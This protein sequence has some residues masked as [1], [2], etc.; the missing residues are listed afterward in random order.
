MYYE[1]HGKGTPLL[2]LHGFTGTSWGL[3]SIFQAFLQDYQLIIPDLRGHGRTTNPKKTYT[4][5]QVAEDLLSLLSHLNIKQCKAIGFSG[6]G[7]ALLHLATLQPELVQS[8]VLVSA[9]HYFPEHAKHIM[10]QN[11]LESKTQNDWEYMRKL[12]IHGD[13]Q[14]RLL[15]DQVRGMADNDEDVHFSQDDLNEISAHTLII[16]GDRDPLYPLELTLEMYR[17]IPKSYLWIVP[18][19]GHCP[20]SETNISSFISGMKFI[21]EKD[22]IS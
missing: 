7:I 2:I 12:H 9:T 17:N 3:S 19:S 1:V 21:L 14:I 8:M 4:F 20:I 22:N 15:W 5:K 16:Q 6:G 11:I 13:D 10:R 18:N